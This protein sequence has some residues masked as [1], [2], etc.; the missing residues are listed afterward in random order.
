MKKLWLMLVSVL[1]LAACSD[2][3]PEVPTPDKPKPE[4]PE[5]KPEVKPGPF[6]GR[7][8]LA[9]IVS[10][11]L[12]N[13]LKANLID[14]YKGLSA[15][16]DSVALMVYYRPVY[17]DASLEGPS[18]LK[19]VCNGKGKINGK[20]IIPASDL[21]ISD[22]MRCTDA[23]EKAELVI[24]QAEI[25]VS[26]DTDEYAT[27]P[28][29]L[30]RVLKEMIAMAPSA[31]YGLTMGS[32]GTGWLPGN[33]VQ[34]RSFGDDRGTNINIPELGEALKAV[35]G[36]KKLDYILFDACMMANAEVV[37]ELRESTDHII[38]SVLETSVYGHPYEE[39]FENL[40]AN[41]V[42]YQQIC[43][44][45]ITFN[46]RRNLWGTISVM[47]CSK[48][49]KLAEWVNKELKENNSQLGSGFQANVM[50][51]GVYHDSFSDYSNYSYDVVDV[52][53]QLENGNLLELEMLMDE[54]VVAKN[55]LDGADYQ[56]DEIVIDKDRYSGLGMYLPFISGDKT[57]NNISW[58]S[59]YL[60]AFGWAKAVEWAN[61]KP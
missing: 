47:D 15:S 43:D 12:D 13:Y 26:E 1:M 44:A 49:E 4:Q 23:S 54:L 51:Y 11:N 39:I 35:F 7:T 18:I 55:C 50:Q 22:Q 3:V 16:K 5:P 41:K 20:D 32:H 28:Q 56:F 53:R 24:K 25:V 30:E 38:A 21:E 27:D 14:M 61:Y 31:S 52:F 58:D 19:F 36:E 59:Y 37:Y 34:S 10:N 8:L 48:I 9:Y 33:P 57:S 45:F 29:V 2:E 40:Y 46:T 42:D 60:S 17:N 6:K